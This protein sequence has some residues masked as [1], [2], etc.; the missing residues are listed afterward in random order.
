M[1]SEREYFRNYRIRQNNNIWDWFDT[2]DVIIDNDI[3]SIEIVEGL[4]SVFD[5][6]KQ[7]VYCPKSR[8]YRITI[9]DY[10]KKWI[11]HDMVHTFTIE[12][13][14]WHTLLFRIT[15]K[16]CYFEDPTTNHISYTIYHQDYCITGWGSYY[17]KLKDYKGIIPWLVYFP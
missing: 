13:I 2:I 12:R 9:N 11:T 15:K 5:E 17:W 7:F 16:G 4:R 10:S 3:D 6:V 1:F 14:K 8:R